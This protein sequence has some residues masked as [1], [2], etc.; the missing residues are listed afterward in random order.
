[1]R[2]KH[3]HENLLNVD[4]GNVRSSLLNLFLL[5]RKKDKR[6]IDLT[7]DTLDSDIDESFYDCE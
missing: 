7:D 5:K 4:D 1:M 3:K 6:F 2:H